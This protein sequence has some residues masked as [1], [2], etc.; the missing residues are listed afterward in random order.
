MLYEC[1][2]Y[3]NDGVLYGIVA[4]I[5]WR[6]FLLFVRGLRMFTYSYNKSNGLVDYKL[7]NYLSSGVASD[8]VEVREL[9]WWCLNRG[10]I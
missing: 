9:Y 4:R 1:D 6:E 7:F 8:E 5:G 10:L 3:T 2:N